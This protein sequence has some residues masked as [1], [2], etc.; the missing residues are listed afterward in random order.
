M[1]L[2]YN[3]R[4]MFVPRAAALKSGHARITGIYSNGVDLDMD[5]GTVVW[6]FNDEI[7]PITKV[8]PIEMWVDDLR[9]GYR[10]Q[11]MGY[12]KS[13]GKYCCLGVACAVASFAGVEMDVKSK[14]GISSYDGSTSY[15]PAAVMNWLG[16]TTP[17]VLFKPDT[18]ELYS[19]GP[20]KGYTSLTALNDSYGFTFAE[21][22]AAVEWLFLGKDRPSKLN[23]V[24]IV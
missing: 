23:A 15:L 12:L 2:K 19:S 5:D 11:G 6:A 4:V 1:T 18:G 3:D 14:N 22:A 10:P 20:G 24:V 9:N 17:N 13:D 21:I 8:T 16:V 7:S